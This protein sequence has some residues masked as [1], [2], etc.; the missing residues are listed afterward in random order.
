MEQNK[1][2]IIYLSS[3]DEELDEIIYYIVYKLKNAQAAERLL[4]TI[5]KAIM[6]RSRNPESFEV[7]KSKNIRKYTWYRIYVKNFIIFYVVRN[8]VMEIAHIIY[9]KRNLEEF[10]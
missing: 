3:F 9:C 6:D 7:Y 8:N 2:D 4:E 5:E 1:Y 10:I